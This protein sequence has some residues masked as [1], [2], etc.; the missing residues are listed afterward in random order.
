[1]TTTYKTHNQ[2]AYRTHIKQIKYSRMLYNSRGKDSL[3]SLI[4]HIIALNPPTAV[5][6][7]NICY[8]V[9]RRQYT[10]DKYSDSMQWWDAKRGGIIF[11]RVQMS[12]RLRDLLSRS[13]SNIIPPQVYY[14]PY[15]T[16]W[17]QAATIA[18]IVDSVLT[19][20]MKSS[21]AQWNATEYRPRRLRFAS[22]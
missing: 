13:F 22:V 3:S 11:Q 12:A 17:Q 9:M 21:S 16:F 18:Y 6:F 15:S 14:T 5:L 7:P 20:P 8:H 4:K 1:M 10:K 19:F 2:F